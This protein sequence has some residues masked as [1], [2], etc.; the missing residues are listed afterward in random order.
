MIRMP[1][2]EN[3]IRAACKTEAE[4][5][6]ELGALFLDYLKAPQVD[7]FIKE[8]ASQPVAILGAVRSPSRFQ[9]QRR[10]KLL[11]LISFA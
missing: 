7:V 5:A 4:L 8:Y 3:D 2:I 9:L 11:E 10:V 6:K 1:F